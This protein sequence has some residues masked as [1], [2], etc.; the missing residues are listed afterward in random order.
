KSLYCYLCPNKIFK[1]QQELNHYKTIV[2]Y[3]Y[4]ISLK[5]I[6]PLLQ[7]ALDKFKNILVYTIQKQLKNNTKNVGLQS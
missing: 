2:H 3:N 4:N 6:T 5:Y 1:N 7:E